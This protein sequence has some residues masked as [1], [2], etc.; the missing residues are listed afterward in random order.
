MRCNGGRATDSTSAAC[1]PSCAKWATRSAVLRVTC[2]S[3][4]SPTNPAVLRLFGLIKGRAPALFARRED[5]QVA[6]AGAAEPGDEPGGDL[7]TRSLPTDPSIEERTPTVMMVSEPLECVSASATNTSSNRQWACSRGP[8][9]AA[10]RPPASPS[11][12]RG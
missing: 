4:A 5:P 6:Y 1:A 9:S 10:W 8:L 11:W 12:R 7:V 3:F 2:R